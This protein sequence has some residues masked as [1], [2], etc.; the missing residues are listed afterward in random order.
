MFCVEMGGGAGG[1]SGCGGFSGAGRSVF[2]L[3]SGGGGGGHEIEESINL[4]FDV[5]KKRI[6]FVGFTFGVI[7]N[8]RLLLKMIPP[9]RTALFLFLLKLNDIYGYD[10]MKILNHQFMNELGWIM[11]G[12]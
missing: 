7:A 10:I 6:Y 8:K 11:D 2:T 1:G 3:A 4:Y 5:D 12:T 9:P